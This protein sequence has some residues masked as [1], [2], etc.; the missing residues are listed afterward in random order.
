MSEIREDKLI[1]S[2]KLLVEKLRGQGYYRMNGKL[3]PAIR[4]QLDSIIRQAVKLD[5]G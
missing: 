1:M 3:P 2:C 5:E 4:K